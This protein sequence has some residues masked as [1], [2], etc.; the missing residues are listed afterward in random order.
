VRRTRLL[1]AVLCVAL[2]AAGLEAAPL[3]D[4]LLRFR[5]VRTPHFIVY[6]HAGEE[7]LASRLV[8]LVEGAR[9]EVGAALG[10]D[11]PALTHVILADQSEQANGWATP[12]PRNTIFLNA[13]APSGGEFIGRTDD[14]LRLV[15]THEY[16]HIVHLDRSGGWARAVR[17]LFG[18]NGVAFPNLWL[19]QWQ[20]EGIATFEESALTGGGRQSAGDFRAIERV[21]ALAGRTLSLD[22][23]SGGLVAWPDGHAAYAAGL[24]FH[25]YLAGRFG[26]ASFGRLATATSRRLPFLG[27]RAFRGV[28]GQPLGALWREY[29]AS[30]TAAAGTAPSPPP[31]ARRL[32]HR[33]QMALGPRF[34]PALCPA[35]PAE[36]L[37][38]SRTPDAFPQMRA[39]TVD[40]HRDVAV[41]TRY[42][43][44]TVGLRSRWVV[45]D[46]QEVRRSV[47]LYSELFVVDRLSGDR[48]PVAGT[49]RLREPDLSPSGTDIVA[50][51]E[52]GG[53]R[54][55]VIARLAAPVDQDGPMR[56]NTVEV[57][58]AE[59]DTQFNAPRWSPDGRLV[60]V[61]RRRTGAL[62]D[63]VLV[64]ATTRAVRREWSDG[65][66]R[67]VTPTW[68]PD[69]QA[70]VVAADFDG[71]PFDLFE[72]EL[73][74]Q[75]RARRLTRTQGAFWPDVAPDGRTLTFAG[76]SASGYDIFVAPYSLLA[77]AAPRELT[78][79]APPA[80]AA[81]P[82]PSARYTPWSTLGPTSWTPFG[83]VNDTQ[84]RLGGLVTGADVL[85]RH[86]WAL[87]ASWMLSGPTVVRPLAAA[88][89]D[90]SAS[91][92]YARWRP[93]WFAGAS[94]QAVF[95]TISSG[96]PAA[97]TE[98]A[99]L[100]TEVQ[101]GVFVPFVHLR[102][103]A[104]VFGAMAASDTRYR[105]AS[106]DRVNRTV[107]ARLAASYDS[108]ER[109]GYSIS[110]E[111]GVLMGTTVELARR[112]L[113]SRA[114]A[115]TATLD[116]RGYLPGLGTHH[117]VALRAAGGLSQGADLARQLFSLG[118]VGASPGVI[119][120]GSSALGLMRGGV[121][122]TTSGDQILVGNV[123]YRLPLAILERGRGTWPLLIRTLHSTVFADVAQLRGTSRVGAAWTRAVGG[124]LS[125]DAVAGYG[126]PFVA[127]VG[128]AWGGDAGR[129]AGTQV[130]A[131]IGRAF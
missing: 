59:D 64:D 11:A 129:P 31:L 131:R 123:E 14:W 86:A 71:A 75:P 47:G 70:I 6:F 9:A 128:V 55:L 29:S 79:K 106:E 109:L 66:A 15:F 38:A 118:A 28:Y 87:G 24:G 130:Y 13:A 120:F 40:G 113:G 119:D 74:G 32:T 27:T 68:R 85:G 54:E 112:A 77:D 89:P 48:R 61:E 97:V 43:G 107:A 102:Q 44:A 104:Q 91:Y 12:L 1:A 22:R 25:E 33:G 111:R 49:G 42:L 23:A 3:L 117:V 110:R 92:A 5:Q 84:T 90:W 127:T 8:A 98:V 126:L 57:V 16:T 18:R 122:G 17:G 37:Y 82:L 125:L 60:V 100:E 83:V 30:L 116:I 93:T 58:L 101:A 36:I 80:A 108:T 63:I 10:L 62:P 46:Q 56:V 76:Y 51:R 88:A 114:E 72:L 26:E 67:L 99:G 50:V 41:T 105:L 65:A 73:E 103:S 124:E 53:S 35:C 4:P 39:V 21:G 69:G 45:F 121:P 78:A 95:R 20:V 7:R 34:A 81:A 19:P 52:R 96:T 115:T 2:Y 94:R